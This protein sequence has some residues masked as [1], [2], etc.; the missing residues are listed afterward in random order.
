MTTL[1]LRHCKLNEV[2]D[3]F[4]SLILRS[5]MDKCSGGQCLDFILTSVTAAATKTLHQVR[6]QT[7][8]I[9]LALSH[10]VMLPDFTNRAFGRSLFPSFH[11]LW[12][13]LFLR[14]PTRCITLSMRGCRPARQPLRQTRCARGVSARMPSATLHSGKVP[15][16]RC[17]SSRPLMRTL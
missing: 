5:N 15:H 1:V 9:T 17:A 2:N 3:C 4:H 13:S 11:P 10:H 16:C 14:L 7:P 6:C 12:L 8:W